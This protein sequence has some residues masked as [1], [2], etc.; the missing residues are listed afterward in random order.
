MKND[1]G[2]STGDTRGCP[3]YFLARLPDDDHGRQGEPDRLGTVAS[4]GRQITLDAPAKERKK[5]YRNR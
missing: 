2:T 5:L 4:N 3:N 1:G